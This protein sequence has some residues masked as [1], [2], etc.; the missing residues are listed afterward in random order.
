MYCAC[1]GW[2]RKKKKNALD[3]NY[4]YRGAVRAGDQSI[5]NSEKLGL[6]L[7]RAGQKAR[8]TSCRCRHAGRGIISTI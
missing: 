3:R 6:A 7:E 1:D 8:S 4:D 2:T 5:E